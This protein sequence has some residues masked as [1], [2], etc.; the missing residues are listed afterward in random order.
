M[1]YLSSQAAA[2]KKKK[3]PRNAYKNWTGWFNH[4]SSHK[5][6]SPDFNNKVC[7]NQMRLP[8]GVFWKYVE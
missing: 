8:T 4:K 2:K 7:E 3:N 6:T 1:K 5:E